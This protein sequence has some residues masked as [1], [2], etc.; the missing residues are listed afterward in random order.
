MNP[1]DIVA[2]GEPMIE[3]NQQPG[4]HACIDRAS[5]ARAPQPPKAEVPI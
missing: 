2:I 1:P 3:F 4:D 5:A